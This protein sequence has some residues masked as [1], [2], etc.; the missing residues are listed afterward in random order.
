MYLLKLLNNGNQDYQQ[1]SNYIFT[2]S[3]LN[4]VS[5]SSVDERAAFSVSGGL[6]ILS[7]YDGVFVSQL[8]YA[9]LKWQCL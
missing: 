9:P 2:L 3:S 5:L 8:S 6:F 1:R 4:Y 7:V